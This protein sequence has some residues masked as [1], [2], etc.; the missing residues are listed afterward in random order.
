MTHPPRTELPPIAIVVAMGK[1]TRVI[2]RDNKIIW[3]VPDDLKRFAAKTRGKPVI[4]GRKTFQSIVDMI[5]RPLPD[6]PNIVI[7]RDPAYAYEGATTTNSLDEALD[8]AAAGH[9]DEIH[10]G[11]GAEIYSKILPRVDRLYVTFFDDDAPGDTYFPEFEHL[12]VELARH[13]RR[14]H[15]GLKYEWV[16]Y[17]SKT[18]C[19]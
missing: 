9:P 15:N 13:G 7:S 4:M 19:T 17:V 11:G 14:E 8:L 12:F 2:G 6:R 3:H 16:D 10:I 5:G 1:Q 18:S